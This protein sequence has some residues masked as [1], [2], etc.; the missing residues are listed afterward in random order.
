MNF[1]I[2]GKFDNQYCMHNSTCGSLTKNNID[3]NVVICGWV[4]RL[5]NLG[6]FCFLTLRDRTGI[7][8]VLIS[9]SELGMENYEQISHFGREYVLRI[10]GKVRSR[11]EKDKN[12]DMPTGEIEVVAKK[13]SLLNKSK[14][15]PFSID[16]DIDTSDDMK[17]KWRFLDLR[18]PEMYKTLYI[19]HKFA[20]AIRNSLDKRGF[21]D[22][23]TP[24]LANPTPEGAR[25]YVVPSRVNPGCFYALP[26]SPQQFKQLLMVSG[27]ER[28]YQ[29]ARC[30]RDEDLR[31][32]RQPEFTQ[33]DIEMSFVK[34]DEVINLTEDVIIESLGEVGINIE[35][36]L[37]RMQYWD[38]LNDYG[39]D[40]PDLRFEMKLQDISHIAKSCGFKVFESVVKC[41]GVVKALVAKGAG[42][43]SR[44]NVDNLVKVARDNGASG[45]A[46]ILVRKDGTISSSFAKF[47]NEDAL[48]DIKNT[49][50][51]QDGD[52]ALFV[53]DKFKVACLSLGAVRCSLGKSLDLIDRDKHSLLW[54]VN[55]PMFCIDEE[56]GKY[57]AE[58]HPFT[59]VLD[60]DMD[61]IKTN[62]LECGSHSYDLIMDGYE[63]GGG[64]IRIH[65]AEE[66]RQVLQ[67]CGLSDSEID[68]KFGH[69]LQALELGCPPHG[70]IALG[71]D[72][73]VMLIAG[74]DSIRDVIAFPKTTSANDLMT[75]APIE[76]SKESLDELNLK[77]K[78]SN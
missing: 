35:S 25:D 76:I 73:L 74:R 58:H 11:G 1:N 77:I 64:T 49:L 78:Q 2:E 36:S 21:I 9:P 38:A 32:D 14:T 40:R 5:R 23:E 51:I 65:N 29:I 55:F 68:K 54:V 16:D 47:L 71:L 50:N 6:S 31:A 15:P 75:N 66:Q 48:E 33:V 18:R 8:Q 28:Y 26:Q 63:V 62:P 44:K 41:G 70:G 3:D 67:V 43:W 22:I 17:L 52:M 20:H 57:S 61:K 59:H 45:L 72:R 56:T 4:W 53:A 39:S 34:N 60:S 46:Y 12:P 27:V 42:D 13:V 69:L 10:E 37:Q 24:I 7:V 30:F 19:R